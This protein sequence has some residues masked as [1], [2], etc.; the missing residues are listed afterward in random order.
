MDVIG[1]KRELQPL[2]EKVR[3]S[4]EARGLDGLMQTLYVY[5]LTRK[6]RYPALEHASTELF[7]YVPDPLQIELCNRIIDF[8]KMGGEVIVAKLLQ[9]RLPQH[10]FQTMDLDNLYIM[11]G[12]NW[13][14][15]DTIGERVAG[16]ALLTVPDQ[17]IPILRL[18]S[19]HESK[20]VVR[21]VGAATHY[22]VKS[23][24]EKR[25]V[26]DVFSILLHHAS[27]TDFHIK[28]GIGWAVKTIAK[29]HPDVID[30]Y[31]DV[32]ERNKHIGKWMRTKI[33]IGLS[34]S[35]KYAGKYPG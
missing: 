1:S 12:A 25:Y 17:T 5:I 16:Y 24:L 30:K 4:Y 28:K 9:L 33:T 14:T 6:I 23:G 8:E 31:A 18:S 22:A 20:W 32:L 3:A 35:Y 7:K 26:E 29:F 21:S 15:C 11:R 13:L 10:F 2:L 27:A 19:V 34:R